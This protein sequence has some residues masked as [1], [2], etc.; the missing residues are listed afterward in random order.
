M[1]SLLHLLLLALVLIGL[2]FVQA[3]GIVSAQAMLPLWLSTLASPWLRRLQRF[4]PWRLAW[5]AAVLLVFT[6]LVRHAATTGLL[7]LLEDGLLLTALCQV[8][9]LNNVGE[10]QRPDLLFFNSVLIAFVTSLFAADL[11]WCVLFVLHGAVLVPALQVAVFARRGAPAVRAAA[12]A[13]LRDGLQRAVAVGAV[14]AAAFLL[15]PRD[16]HRQG[17]L[18]DLG[19][20]GAAHEAGLADRIRLGDERH[21]ALGDMVV[22]RVAPASGRPED[23]P[24]HWR[25]IAF[26]TFE[27]NTWTKQDAR[28]L[29]SRFATDPAWTGGPGNVWRRP[30]AA[31]GGPLHVRQFDLATGQLLLPLGACELRLDAAAGLLLDPRSSGGFGVLRLDGSAGPVAHTLRVAAGPGRVPVSAR[32]LAVLLQLP[33]AVPPALRALAGELRGQL[34]QG[35]GPA[36]TAAHAADF[37]RRHRRYQLPGGPGFARNLEEFVLGTAPGHCEYFATTLALLLRL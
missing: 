13:L 27:T 14:A 2:G 24:A 7:F 16:F 33:D 17:W 30:S 6:L 9:L 25:G 20:V 8:H 37:L 36:A 10:R 3:T 21:V 19:G 18:G 34:P 32:A 35:A 4:W 12:G 23:V 1:P 29:G 5:N 22:L 15:L 28:Q 31:A 26:A 11:S